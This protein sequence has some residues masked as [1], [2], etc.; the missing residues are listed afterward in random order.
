M[1]IL[2][3]WGT[4][5]GPNTSPCLPTLPLPCSQ[6]LRTLLRFK[7]DLSKPTLPSKPSEDRLNLKSQ[8]LIKHHQISN[9]KSCCS[10]IPGYVKRPETIA[11][12]K[13]ALHSNYYSRNMACLP[14]LF[15]FDSAFQRQRGTFPHWK[16]TA[17][18]PCKCNCYFSPLSNLVSSYGEVFQ[19]Y[20]QSDTLQGQLSVAQIFPTHSGVEEAFTFKR[21]TARVQHFQQ[22]QSFK[23]ST[24]LG[25]A[26]YHRGC[27]TDNTAEERPYSLELEKPSKRTLLVQ[28]TNT[29]SH[30]HQN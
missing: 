3:S 22:H 14:T 30:A 7:E 27:T 26:P 6:M 18:F 19:Q 29:A 24:C 17:F 21:K 16:F 8:A 28:E 9:E 11:D 20:I 10:V 5:R 15:S 12:W 1:A 13:P 2:Q 4:G 25:T 23:I